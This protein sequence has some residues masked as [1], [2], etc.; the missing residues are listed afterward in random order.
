MD[1]DKQ[2]ENLTRAVRDSDIAAVSR[3]C[4]GGVDVNYISKKLVRIRLR[5]KPYS[6]CLEKVSFTRFKK[7]FQSQFYKT[8]AFFSEFLL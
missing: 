7:Y 2:I 4:K 1:E 3:L 6:M 5:L 8:G